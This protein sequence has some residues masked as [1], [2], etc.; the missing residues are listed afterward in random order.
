MR[1]V[2]LTDVEWE[3]TD[4]SHSNNEVWWLLRVEGNP[5]PQWV[6]QDLVV[7][8]FITKAVLGEYND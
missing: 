8:D 1:E 3:N 4:I 6:P 2:F 5:Y 7:T